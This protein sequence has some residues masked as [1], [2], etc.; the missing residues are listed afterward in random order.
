MAVIWLSERTLNDIAGVLPNVTAVAPSKPV[1]VIVTE[2]PPAV[3]PL[4][5]ETAVTAGAAGPCRRTDRPGWWRKCR[6]DP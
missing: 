5:G 2:V 3:E 6:W 4:A 1:P